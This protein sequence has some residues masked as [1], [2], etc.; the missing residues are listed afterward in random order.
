MVSR[1][2]Q[3]KGIDL[4]AYGPIQDPMDRATDFFFLAISL[5]LLLL[6]INKTRD[7]PMTG[8][9]GLLRSRDTL[10]EGLTAAWPFDDVAQI[11]DGRV[12]T[13]ETIE[14]LADLIERS[15]NHSFA[16]DPDLFSQDI[17]RLISLKRTIFATEIVLD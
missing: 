13:E 9:E 15:R 6:N 1:R 14:L 11:S 8:C 12:E 16:K 2:G 17:D 10:L 7:Q 3:L 5:L 4:D